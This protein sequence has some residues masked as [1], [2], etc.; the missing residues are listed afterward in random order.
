MKLFLDTEF[1]E[2][3]G[4]LISMAL[5]PEDENAPV[6]YKELNIIEPYGAWVKEHVVPHLNLAPIN[7]LEF[8][9]ELEKYL[10]QFESITIIADWPDDIRY[11]CQALMTAPG[12]MLTTPN[13]ITFQMI[14]G[15]D[16]V[17][18]IPHHALHDAIGMRNTYLYG[19]AK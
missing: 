6:F 10:R 3:G 13:V 9:Y 11:F 16:Y 18:A 5:V 2:F 1:N 4:E 17:S 15:L 7:T 14:R 8:Q 12:Y 19:L